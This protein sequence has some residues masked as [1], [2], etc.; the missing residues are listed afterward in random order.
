MHFFLS[1]QGR[2]KKRQGAL[3]PESDIMNW[4]VQLCLAVK[5]IHDRKILHRDIKS[6]N[7]F[8]T[9]SESVVKVGRAIGR[10]RAPAALCAL[11][12]LS[13]KALNQTITDCA[14]VVALC[15]CSP[16]PSAFSLSFALGSWATLGSPSRSPRRTQRPPP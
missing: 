12:L 9:S 15:A 5:H 13:V 1:V 2:I 10:R 7:I 6:Q 16:R 11:L 14:C 8:L 3:F 4:L